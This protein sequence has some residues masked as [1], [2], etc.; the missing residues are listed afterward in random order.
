MRKYFKKNS[1][2]DLIGIITKYT[3]GL[4]SIILGNFVNDNN[5]ALSNQTKIY[6]ITEEDE[7]LFQKIISNFSLTLFDKEGFVTIS[8]TDKNKHVSAQI[9]QN[10]L[11]ILQKKIIEFK[12]KSSKELLVFV[13]AQYVEKKFLYE[14]LQ[15]K[16]AIFLD[17][18]QNIS[19]S[20]Y[21]NKLTRLESEL[22]INQS[23]V[24]QLA[25]QVEQAKLKL[26]KDTPVFST[27][28]PTTI[29][30]KK[31]YPFRSSI[32]IIFTFLGF[33]F[34]TLFVLTKNSFLERLNLIKS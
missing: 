2:F 9:V 6:S 15:D 20:L 23:V 10:S 16:K 34:S 17:K 13:Q 22:D 21:L 32:V 26:N 31:S 3:L 1:S 19:S 5:L 11:N 8:Y 14:K 33:L 30:F 24:Q 25:S 4:P 28:D 12:N 7:K 18:N 29:P 27:I